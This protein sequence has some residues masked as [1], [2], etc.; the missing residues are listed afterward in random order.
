M[1]PTDDT[2]NHPGG[3][4]GTDGSHGPHLSDGSGAA[5]DT[6]PDAHP[7]HAHARHAHHSERLTF[8]ERLRARFSRNSN[9]ADGRHAPGHEHAEKRTAFVLAGGGSR[10]A[11]QVGMLDELVRR[12]IR[13]DRVY[14]ASVGAI[15]GAAYAG[16]PTLDGIDHMADVWRNVSGADVFPRGTFDGPWAYFQKRPAVHANSG[17]RK[18]IEAG[19]TFEDLEDAQIPI[20]VVTTSLTDGRE[21]WIARGPA[22]EAIL[23]S[24]AIPAMFPPVMI[25]GDLLID[26]GVVNNVPISRALAA[27][28]DRVYVL[29]CGPLHYHPQPP[30]R[31]AEAVLTAFFVAVHARFVRELAALPPGVEVIVFSGGGDPSGQYRDF[32]GTPALLEEGR[33]EVAAVLDRYAGTSHDLG[34]AAAVNRPPVAAGPGPAADPAPETAPT[35]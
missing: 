7:T 23:A 12:G 16:N 10:G 25:D 24:S 17:L 22:V 19:L 5:D 30:R 9:R 28:C 2:G 11:V 15:N 33:A 29:L 32:S 3:P 20:E 34:V 26:G 6:T 31:P 13:A 35:A 18:I 1:T 14:G 8:G 21:R 4:D 27:Q